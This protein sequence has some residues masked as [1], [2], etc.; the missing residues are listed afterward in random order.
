MTVP[1]AVHQA[2]PQH[3]AQSKFMVTCPS[4]KI[5]GNPD[6]CHPLPQSDSCRP[7]TRNLLLDTAIGRWNTIGPFM[8]N[9]SFRVA[10]L[11]REHPALLLPYVAADLLAIFLWRL[12]GQA[13]KVIFHWFATGHLVIGIDGATPRLSPSI[14]AKASLTY[15]PIGITTI[16]SVMWLFVAAL[17]GT[18][19]MV[20]SF[21]NALRLL[22]TSAV[23][24]AGTVFLAYWLLY[25]A[26]HRELFFP[27]FLLTI[28]MMPIGTGCTAWLVLPAAM[29]LIRGEANL[30]STKI[31][32]QGTIVAVLTLEA[33]EMIAF[34]LPTLEKR[35]LLN[36]EETRGIVWVINSVVANSPYALLFIALALLASAS[37]GQEDLNKGSKLPDILSVLMPLHFDPSKEPPGTRS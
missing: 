7:L 33:G 10:D 9:L 16:V 21:E 34:L 25:V 35:V 4:A 19:M 6:L 30:V 12:R 27:S 24:T 2:P 11:L 36:T 15:T 31:K 18:A 17:V 13:E 32:K 1:T 22:I 8:R 28:A 26:H 23:L 3:Q 20:R 5:A 29:R 14:F 37:A